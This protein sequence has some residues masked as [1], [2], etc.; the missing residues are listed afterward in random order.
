MIA[1]VIKDLKTGVA[2]Y[3]P[4][5]PLTQVLLDIVIEANLTPYPQDW[6][7]DLS[8]S[9]SAIKQGD[10]LYQEFVDE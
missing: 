9:L 8:R 2:Q 1:R 4:A 7:E 5:A 6:K 3:G 10:S